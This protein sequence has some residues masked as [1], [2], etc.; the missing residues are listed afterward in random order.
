MPILISKNIFIIHLQH[1]VFTM[2]SIYWRFSSSFSLDCIKGVDN[3][4]ADALSR[5]PQSDYSI[6]KMELISPDANTIKNIG[7]LSIELDHDTL[8]E[9]LLHHPSLPDKFFIQLENPILHSC[10]I[11][12]ISCTQQQMNPQKYPTI[13]L[14]GVNIHCYVTVLGAPWCIVI[15]L[16]MLDPIILHII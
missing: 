8:L 5:L 7:T 13:T 10:Q 15:S 16:S 1:N 4:I 2:A 12:D 3:V 11:Q 9:T 6:T 14:D